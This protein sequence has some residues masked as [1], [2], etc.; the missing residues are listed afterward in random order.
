MGGKASTRRTYVGRDDD[1]S[2]GRRG[3]SHGR[4]DRSHGRR[5]TSCRRHDHSHSRRRHCSLRRNG[6]GSSGIGRCHASSNSHGARQT[7]DHQERQQTSADRWRTRADWSCSCADWRWTPADERCRWFAPARRELAANRSDATT[8]AR[9]RARTAADP[10]DASRS[11]AGSGS[12]QEHQGPACCAG[13][14]SITARRSSVMDS[15]MG[16]TA[17]MARMDE[18]YPGGR[19]SHRGAGRAGG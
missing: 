16:S 1:G 17:V 2:N 14:G 3:C 6:H 18:P 13:C 7:D 15:V 4:R 11:E 12:G 9:G 10:P 8:R 19:G 5:A